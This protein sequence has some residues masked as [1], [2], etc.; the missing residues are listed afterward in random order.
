MTCKR[1]AIFAWAAVFLLPLIACNQSSQTPSSKA[2]AATS[3]L[4]GGLKPVDFGGVDLRT[5]NRQKLE[6]VYYRNLKVPLVPRN[7]FESVADA[8]SIYPG[9]EKVEVAMT[10]GGALATMQF[11]FPGTGD[12]Y[13]AD[14]VTQLMASKYGKPST[15][16]GKLEQGEYRAIWDMGGGFIIQVGRSWPNTTTHLNFVSS[17]NLI[18]LQEEVQQRLHSPKNM[19][20]ASR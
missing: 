16:L 4:A 10:R 1:I 15:I 12:P 8:S 5:V 9:A 11:V 13:L 2:S 14:K 18:R 3:Q 7:D 6:E 17:G 20:G 19:V